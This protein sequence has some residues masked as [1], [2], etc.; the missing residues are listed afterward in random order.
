MQEF[1]LYESGILGYC[2]PRTMQISAQGGLVIRKLS[3]LLGTVVVCVML[4]TA[5]TALAQS[6]TQDAYGGE[7]A[8]LQETGG[9][10]GDGEGPQA[11]PA[12]E[13]GGGGELPFTGFQLGLALALGAGLVAAGVT[14]RRVSRAQA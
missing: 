2:G 6:P 13:A 7:A 12:R 1:L 5:G 11:V 10:G 3:L 14:V 4:A 9:N 8:T